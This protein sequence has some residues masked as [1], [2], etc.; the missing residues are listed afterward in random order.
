MCGSTMGKLCPQKKA[1]T[2]FLLC[3]TVRLSAATLSGRANEASMYVGRESLF[4]F[5]L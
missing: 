3:K 5:S 1:P 2:F 4:Y